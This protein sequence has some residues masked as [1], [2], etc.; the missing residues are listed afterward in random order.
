MPHWP[1]TTLEVI[2]DSLSENLDQGLEGEKPAKEWC[3]VDGRSKRRLSAASDAEELASQGRAR[4]RYDGRSPTTG[5][6]R[7]HT[8]PQSFEQRLRSL[9]PALNSIMGPPLDDPTKSSSKNILLARFARLL[10]TKPSR[11]SE[12][13][14]SLREIHLDWLRAAFIL[15][16]EVRTTALPGQ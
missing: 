1:A 9:G 15:Q 14:G 4:P 6:P 2:R 13:C 8:K 5:S 3:S 7:L 11:A 16:S 12:V 10:L